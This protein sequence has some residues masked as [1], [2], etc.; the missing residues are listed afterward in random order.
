MRIRLVGSILRYVPCRRAGD[1]VDVALGLDSSDSP[2]QQLL[3]LASPTGT[4]DPFPHGLE[5]VP[6]GRSVGWRRHPCLE[7]AERCPGT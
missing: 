1:Q 5:R 7:V 4:V 6:S 3:L 2:V